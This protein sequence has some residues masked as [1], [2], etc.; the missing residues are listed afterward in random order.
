MPLNKIWLMKS[1][2][3]QPL[4]PVEPSHIHP[5][6]YAGIEAREKI[7]ELAKILKSK[8]ADCCVLTDPSSI[9]WAFNIRGSDIPHTPLALS[10][11]ILHSNGR[12]QLYIDKGKLDIETHAYL[13]QLVDIHAPDAF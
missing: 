2:E 10:F 1:G 7:T 13:T 9:A 12:P 8:N 5:I 11:A 4:A 6:K 3:D